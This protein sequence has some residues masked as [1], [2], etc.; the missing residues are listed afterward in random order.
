M[1]NPK[2][3]IKTLSYVKQIFNDFI[4]KF[5]TYFNLDNEIDYED[6]FSKN[7]LNSIYKYKKGIYNQFN[8]E[9]RGNFDINSW[10]NPLLKSGNFYYSYFHNNGSKIYFIYKVFVEKY[11]LKVIKLDN[12]PN[13]DI[14]E[15]FVAIFDNLPDF[16]FYIYTFGG[17]SKELLSSLQS[18]D[19]AIHRNGFSR[20]YSNINS[21]LVKYYFINFHK[22]LFHLK[23]SNFQDISGY[24]YNRMSLKKFLYDNNLIN[25]VPNGLFPNDLFINYYKNDFEELEKKV[26]NYFSNS[27]SITTF[28]FFSLLDIS[29]PFFNET[30][31][32]KELAYY[33]NV[34]NNP[35]RKLLLIA[36]EKN[37]LNARWK[38]EFNLYTLFKKKFD[39]TIYQYHDSWLGLQSIDIYIPS[40]KI[41]IEYQGRQHYESI[42]YFGGDESYKKNRFRDLRKLELCNNNGIKLFEWKYLIE[43]NS[44]EFDRFILKNEILSINKQ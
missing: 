25:L 5:G 24:S 23:E 39:D 9:I 43:V 22:H 6:L 14:S 28:L 32:P 35:F 36:Q 19:G 30:M 12:F 8:D 41:G 34:N 1:I 38:N 13:D 31:L 33:D 17:Y 40:L 42:D 21:S 37:Y 18:Q 2:T 26:N 44:F 27:V 16:S 10:S 15:N 3:N 20:V 29:N 7:T 4:S 11:A